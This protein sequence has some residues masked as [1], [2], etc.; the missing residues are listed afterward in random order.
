VRRVI[1][2]RDL[3]LAFGD[4]VLFDGIGGTIAARERLGL[5]GANGSGKTTLLRILAGQSEP[6]RGRIEKAGYV[7]IGYLPQEEIVASGRSVLAEVEAAF[8]DIVAVRGRI[9]DAGRQLRELPAESP[10]YAHTLE[11]LGELEHRLQDFDAARTRAR[12]EAVL[13]GLGFAPADSARDCGEFSGGWQ[14]RIALA[15]LLLRQPALLLLDEPTNHLD[16][17]SQR[18]LE[19][20]LRDYDG[21]LVLVSHDRAFLDTLCRRTWALSGGR[22]DDY[23]GDYSFYERESASRREQQRQARK[24]QDREIARQQIFIERFRYKATKA[25]QVQ[26][27]IKAL[28][29]IERIDV[30]EEDTRSIRFEFPPPPRSGQVVAELEGVRKCYGSH[31][32]FESLELR[33][34]RGEKVAVV[35]PNGAGKST[36]VRL[37]AGVEPFDAGERRLGHAVVPAW[38]AQHQSRELDPGRTVLE[39]LEEAA[40]PGSAA[41]L[42]AL[43]GAFLFGDDD[44]F[45]PVAVLSGGEKNRLAL[46]RMLVRPSNLLVLDEP[47]NH[48]D[49]RSKGV[50][51]EA[52]AG[53]A[54]TVAVVSHDRSFLDGFI[55]KV[56]EVTPRRLRVFPGKVAEYLERIEAE[57]TAASRARTDAPEQ[58]P[59]GSPPAPAADAR[60]RRRRAAELRRE[61]AP[62]RARIEALEAEIAEA[63]ARVRA[64]EEAMAVPGFYA[65]GQATRDDLQAYEALRARVA[66][67]CEEWEAA[68]AELAARESLPG[69]PP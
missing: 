66:A 55:G 15:R 51:Q 29:R 69:G 42:R 5:V 65:R 52:L 26:S 18:W 62:L 24:A 30:D 41:D 13:A 57:E 10:A 11:V 45:K 43:L 58:L 38:F 54:G 44:V 35:G 31:V 53:F 63:E 48:L 12:A 56:V 68:G 1:T 64:L 28:D 32:V 20:F 16:L 2:V 39:T 49:M 7:T 6:D 36:L 60:E 61:S 46:A 19:R 3:G 22:L 34:E 47:T 67:A 25:R 27:R 23:A 14:M 40:G 17:P 4:R 21:A 37:L 59:A 50:L 8:E 9:D 33:L